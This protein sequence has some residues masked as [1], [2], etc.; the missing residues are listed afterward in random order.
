MATRTV[1]SFNAPVEHAGCACVLGRVVD[2]FHELPRSSTTP[3]YMVD[4]LD[5]PSPCMKECLMSDC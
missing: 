1:V 2:V 4:I 5:A 3:A